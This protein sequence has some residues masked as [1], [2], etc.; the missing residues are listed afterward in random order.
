M[1]SE[2]ADQQDAGMDAEGSRLLVCDDSTDQRTALSGI[3]R[4]RGYE[5]DEA[6][7]GQS[8][9][10]MLKARVYAMV[11]LDLQMPGMDG[12]DVLAYAQKHLPK[13]SVVL[14]SGL[15]AEDIGDGLERLPAHELPPL[16]LKPIDLGQLFR[17]I[18][19]SLAGEL[20]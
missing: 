1:L 9:L 20:P 8:A 16:L 18:E 5:V 10:R 12:F 3:L 14:L 13:L 19:M 15:P 6:A 11:L 17:V 2:I 4:K 7:D